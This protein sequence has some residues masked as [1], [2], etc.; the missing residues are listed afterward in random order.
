MANYPEIIPVP[1]SYLEHYLLDSI[2]LRSSN[3]TPS[4]DP[5]A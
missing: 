2:R 4:A 5:G 1:L 3:D